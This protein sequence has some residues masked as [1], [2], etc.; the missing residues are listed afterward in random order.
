[1]HFWLSGIGV[2]TDHLASSANQVLS[3]GVPSE[4]CKL[5]I[6]RIP[7]VRPTDA[8]QF[9][10]LSECTMQLYHQSEIHYMRQLLESFM[11]N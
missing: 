7:L 1:M 5:P 8:A 2:L 3:R 6:L 9:V 10:R 11:A 4:N